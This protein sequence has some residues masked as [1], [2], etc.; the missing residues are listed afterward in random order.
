[1]GAFCKQCGNYESHGVFVPN[2]TIC[3]RCD[4]KSEFIPGDMLVV[5]KRYPY[6]F[7]STWF[8]KLNK[9][10]E[11]GWLNVDRFVTV[12]KVLQDGNRFVWPGD[13]TLSKNIWIRKCVDGRY[14]YERCYVKVNFYDP[15][16]Q[17]IDI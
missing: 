6:G 7:T 15:L 13:R 16:K 17:Y 11:S 1:M 2:T 4:S 14:R 8:A 9:T 3:I 10:S 5:H 12:E